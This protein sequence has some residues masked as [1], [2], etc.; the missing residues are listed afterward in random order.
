M[1]PEQTMD[2]C[3]YDLDSV[4][5]SSGSTYSCLYNNLINKDDLRYEIMEVKSVCYLADFNIMIQLVI[6]YYGYLKLVLID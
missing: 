6:V 1:N 2:K 5:A 3:V 4:V